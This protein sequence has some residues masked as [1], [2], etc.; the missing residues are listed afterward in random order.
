[1]GGSIDYSSESVDFWPERT[2]ESFLSA[3]YFIG[4][5][6]LQ[7]VRTPEA[8]LPCFWPYSVSTYLILL[9]LYEILLIL[10]LVP[11]FL[12]VKSFLSDKAVRSYIH[13]KHEFQC[14]VD[15]SLFDPMESSNRNHK[16][17]IHS[18]WGKKWGCFQIIPQFLQKL[19]FSGSKKKSKRSIKTQ[20]RAYI[21]ATNWGKK[22]GE[23]STKTS[24]QVLLSTPVLLLAIKESANLGN[25]YLISD[26]CGAS[27][28]W[29]S[30]DL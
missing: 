28:W 6:F 18:I 20:K 27:R 1:M 19:T 10:S 24:K 29:R 11:L 8:S 26:R 4:L 3:S 16:K 21:K 7:T 30:K 9:E 14:K 17:L 22:K 25:A 12:L 23:L 13:F 5:T 2:S 15:V